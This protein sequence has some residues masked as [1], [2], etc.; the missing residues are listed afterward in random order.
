MSG[1]HNLTNEDG[2]EVSFPVVFLDA[3]DGW[4]RETTL[5]QGQYATVLVAPEFDPAAAN[6]SGRTG[7]HRRPEHRAI[8][9]RLPAWVATL[10]KRELAAVLVHEARHRAY[11][12]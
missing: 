12:D 9:G 4:V 10:D 1:R 2:R 5:A 6:Y 7:R 3:F 8:G 11:E